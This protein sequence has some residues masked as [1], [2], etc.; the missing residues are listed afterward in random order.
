MEYAKRLIDQLS[1]WHID[2]RRIPVNDF[3]RSAY[4]MVFDSVM[5]IE[6][7]KVEQPTARKMGRGSY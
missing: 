3:T 2:D 1:A 5:V 7:G 4:S 6:K